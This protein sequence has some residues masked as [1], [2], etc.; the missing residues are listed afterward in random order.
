MEDL[1]FYLPSTK[2]IVKN[3]KNVSESKHGDAG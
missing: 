2:I 3:E 1:K